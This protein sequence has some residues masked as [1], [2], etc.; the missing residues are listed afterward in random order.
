MD[1]RSVF[2]LLDNAVKYSNPKSVIE[3]RIEDYEMHIRVSVITR[4]QL[5]G[6]DE[7]PK[8]FQR[9]YRGKNA[10]R[11]EGVGLGLYL[12][13]EIMRNQKGYVKVS[14]DKKEEVTFSVSF[15][16]NAEETGTAVQGNSSL[17][18][19]HPL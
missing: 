3:I 11:A 4:G 15:R 10:G 14:T 1:G 9:F 2:N 7:I 6:K 16:K 12:V 8:L 5:P 17:Q 19:A 13:R 18:R